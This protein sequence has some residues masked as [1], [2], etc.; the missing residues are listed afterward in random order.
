MEKGGRLNSIAL[1]GLIAAAPAMAETFDRGQALYENHCKDCHDTAAHTRTEHRAISRSDI[2]KWVMTWSFH[3][4]LG[5]SE[6]EIDDVTDFLNRR[7][8][9]F[10]D[11]P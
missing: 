6:E 2:R 7:I 10:N 5:W 1:A 9:H 3:A 8:Y 11:Q 4:A